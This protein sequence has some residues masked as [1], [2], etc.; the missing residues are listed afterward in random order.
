MKSVFIQSWMF[1]RKYLQSAYLPLAMSQM[2]A[3]KLLWFVPKMTS[4]TRNN[5]AFTH[6]GISLISPTH[7]I[8]NIVVVVLKKQRF[9]ICFYFVRKTTPSLLQFSGEWHIYIIMLLSII[10]KRTSLNLKR[11]KFYHCLVFDYYIY[12]YVTGLVVSGLIALHYYFTELIFLEGRPRLLQNL[13]YC[14]TEVKLMK[15]NTFMIHTI[16]VSKLV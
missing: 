13:Y 4:S 7:C 3:M 10:I 8:R 2:M 1:S 16:T 5:E 6:C 12:M 11:T 14:L 15:A 9:W